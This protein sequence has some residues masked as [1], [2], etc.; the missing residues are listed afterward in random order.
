LLFS[1]FLISECF[2]NPFAEFPLNDDWAYS[3]SV[4]LFHTQNRLE[5]GDFGAMSLVLHLFWGIGFTQLFGFSF[6]VLRISTLIS[7]FIGVALVYKIAKGFKLSSGLAFLLSLV[8]LFH[9][10]YFNL[11]NTYMTDVNFNT[12]FLLCVFFAL[13]FFRQNTYSDLFLFFLS[14]TGLIFIRQFG[15]VLPIGFTITLLFLKNRNNKVVLWSL[16]GTALVFFTLKAYEHNLSNLFQS[17]HT[18]KRT[19]DLN[20]LSNSFWISY[21]QHIIL[22]LRVILLQ[23]FVFAG[24]P[25]LMVLPSLIKR[26]SKTVVFVFSFPALLICYYAFGDT[27]FPYAN[28]FNNMCLGPETFYE[29]TQTRLTHTYSEHFAD[30]MNA[31]K[32][33]FSSL[34]VLTLALG[35]YL[36]WK[37]KKNTSHVSL[38]LLI[39]AAFYTALLLIP[40]YLFD[41]YTLPLISL[42]L[43]FSGQYITEYKG[44][45]PTLVLILIMAYVSVSGTKDYFELN[46]NRWK[47]YNHLKTERQ[48]PTNKINAGFEVNCWNEGGESWWANYNE[49]KGYDYLI[50]FKS[51]PGFRHLKTYEFRR[52]FPYKTDKI[53]IF[54]RDSLYT[55]YDK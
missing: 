37:N 43:I 24:V 46:R 8:L 34:S 45:I 32:L 25:A 1:V 30:W 19:G 36:W 41:R 33:I 3:K 5:I 20:L 21:G 13:K 11:S 40:D 48:V 51:E 18:Y 4:F 6:T 49:L 9:P 38:F 44:R 31:V 53:N 10:I 26:T 35:C 50:Q 7:S 39:L 54:V 14:C 47:A 42:A 23:I 15:I 17:A 16:F 52:Y 22:Y 55:H 27:Y 2:V 29:S 28:I 12:L